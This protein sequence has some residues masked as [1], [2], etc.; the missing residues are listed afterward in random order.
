MALPR[1]ALDVLGNDDRVSA[2][3]VAESFDA[4][5]SQLGLDFKLPLY[6]FISRHTGIHP[7]TLMRY[8][9]GQL[10]TA[11]RAL[12]DY[13]RRLLREISRNHRPALNGRLRRKPPV[14]KTQ[15]GHI[16]RVK[17]T[18]VRRLFR[19]ILQKLDVPPNVLYRY[20]GA[21]IGLH[22][23]TV[24]RHANG[25]LKTAPSRLLYHLME[26]KRSV[27]RGNEVVFTRA[28]RGNRVVSRE[29]VLQELDK[30]LKM[31][32]F[33]S[34]L[35]LLRFIETSLM[36][37]P[38]SL[39]R[40]YF[41]KQ[42]IFLDVEILHFLRALIARLEYDPE[43]RY[44]VG[45]PIYHPVFGHGVVVGKEPRDKVT[46][47]FADGTR[48]TLREGLIEVR[49]WKRRANWLEEAHGSPMYNP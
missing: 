24:F 36:L 9:G 22:P 15:N 27:E 16:Q 42:T 33:K 14:A 41:S 5:C 46:V 10:A 40:A 21:E 35:S 29:A 45:D 7:T 6:R 32:V 23:I 13:L 25:K 28:K 2:R 49:E 48:H 12:L 11:P 1:K 3:A 34:K 39:E 38:R 4:L 31:Q 47:E 18:K 43:A 20:M 19:W 17:N 8:H 37:R 30:V 26:L 44:R